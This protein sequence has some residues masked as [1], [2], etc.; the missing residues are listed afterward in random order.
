MTCCLLELW[1][2]ERFTRS[3]W[4]AQTAFYN[5]GPHSERVGP[6]Y[7]ERSNVNLIVRISKNVWIQ[8]H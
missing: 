8:I 1:G 4:R 7:G 2:I 6:E 3:G 5:G